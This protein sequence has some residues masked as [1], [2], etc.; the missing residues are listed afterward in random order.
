MA[1]DFDPRCHIGEVHGIYTIVDMTG[2]KDKYGHWIYKCICNECGFEKF[3]HYGAISGA[4]SITTTCKHLR[5]NGMPII[6]DKRR[7]NNKRIGKIFRSMV[8]R[9]YCKTDRNYQWY[10]AKG[11]EICN[12]WL[13]DPMSFEKW[14]LN[15][16]YTDDL[17]IDRIKSDENYCP[18]NCRWIS[19][20]EN[21][22]RAGKVNW[23]TIGSETLTGRQWAKKIGIGPLTIDRYIRDYGVDVTVQLIEAVIAEPLST[24]YRK[25]HQTWFS[26]YGIQV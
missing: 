13:N 7:W 10:G 16:G 9:C 6:Y 20:E 3:S 25:S 17:T 14:A 2:E 24:K 22:R 12:E 21:S 18:E 23:I 5:A 26:V 8:V 1:K 4:N 19:V 11:I 15:S